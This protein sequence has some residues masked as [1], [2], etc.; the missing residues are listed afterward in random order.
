MFIGRE[1]ELSQLSSLFLKS[2]SSLVVCRGRRRI[3]KSTLIEH[4]GK[5]SHRFLQFQGLAPRNGIGRQEQLDAFSEQ[6]AQQ[7]GLPKMRLD[8]WS[9][10]FALLAN[11]IN[12]LKTVLFLDEI[13]WM[14]TGSPD[15][16]G[17]LKIA[18]DTEFKQKSRLIV[19]L[20]GSVSSWIEKNILN[21]TGFVGRL[22][23]TISLEELP[24]QY[25]NEFWLKKSGKISSREKLKVLAV[26]GGVPRYLEEIRP[27]LSA[28]EN[29]RRLCFSREGLL[30]NEFGQIFNDI[31]SKRSPVYQSI[32]TALAD[33]SRERDEIGKAIK[34]KRGGHLTECLN[35]L[36]LSGFITLDNVFGIRD[37]K[38]AKL[39]KYRLSDNYLR[40]YLKNIVPLAPNIRKGL[41][42][43]V[44]LDDIISWDTIVGLQFE[45]LVIKNIATL[46]PLLEIHPSVV[47]S[48][49]PYFQRQTQRQQGCQVDLLIHTEHSLYLCEMKTNNIIS[50]SVIKSMKEKIER[51]SIPK[52][53][54]VRTVLIYDGNLEKKVQQEGYFDCLVSFDSL[55][56]GNRVDKTK[57]N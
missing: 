17:Y 56:A 20:C 36:A 31:F 9:Q 43:S 10:A 30:F 53:M 38:I 55:L 22:S 18:W 5:T 13:S 44:S 24:L 26:T 33:G 6:L 19:V 14:A 12:G 42:D 57:T 49:S 23:L 48:A 50:S 1:K 2:G 21:N 28:E 15:F 37:N 8:S 32:V 47:K 54:S 41:Y 4:F 46:L 40:F 25:C 7:S 29:I 16:A 3:G 52:G 35:D 45:N 27:S 11:Q 51:L 39:S 34:W